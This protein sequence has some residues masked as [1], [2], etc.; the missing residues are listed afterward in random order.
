[1]LS[2]LADRALVKSTLSGPLGREGQATVLKTDF[3]KCGPVNDL[4]CARDGRDGSWTAAGRLM[5]A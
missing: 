2:K 1:M 5:S 4:D 3:R